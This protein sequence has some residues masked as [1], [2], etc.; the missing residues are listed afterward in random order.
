EGV[1]G[2]VIEG[3]GTA[4]DPDTG[5]R[6]IRRAARGEGVYDGAEVAR[7]PDILI[8][9]GE[10][11]YVASDRLAAGA[12]V[13]PIPP[14][15]GGGRHRRYGIFLAAG[16]GVEPGMIEGANI[17]DV[18]PTALHALGLAVPQGMDG[19]VLTELFSDGRAVEA[20]AA[21]ESEE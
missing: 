12:V 11:P 3:L 17:T 6:I 14:V 19:R 7:I 20:A 1:A 16:P 10:R 4:R 21:G 2:R 9:F 15:G 5:E 8:D 13:E 18:A